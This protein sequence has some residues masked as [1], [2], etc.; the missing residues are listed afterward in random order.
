MLNPHLSLK[1]WLNSIDEDNLN[2][3]AFFF[4]FTPE[5][6]GINSNEDALVNNFLAVIEEYSDGTIESANF[7]V[8]FKALFD[9]HF[10]DRSNEEGWR[11][12]E[13]RHDRLFKHPD[14]TPNMVEHLTKMKARLPE[15]KK[16]W[17]EIYKS[18]NDLKNNALSNK[19]LKAWG[20]G[21]KA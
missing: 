13:E 7:F 19:N 4:S 12:V 9:F 8:T 2:T 5:F 21:F 15:S 16:I 20:I 1:E 17:F 11:V 14:I 18:W 10:E 6:Q 3:I